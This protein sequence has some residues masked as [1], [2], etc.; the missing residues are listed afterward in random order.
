[1]TA[2]ENTVAIILLRISE[3]YFLNDNPFLIFPCLTYEI[4]SPSRR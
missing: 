2:I 1:M 3:R 4:N